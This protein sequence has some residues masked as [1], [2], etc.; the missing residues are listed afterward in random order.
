MPEGRTQCGTATLPLG[1]PV[2]LMIR[3]R[4]ETVT[5]EFSQAFFRLF[6]HLRDRFCGIRR[7]RASYERKEDGEGSNL[8][9]MSGFFAL[10]DFA[11]GLRA[12]EERDD[13]L[14]HFRDVLEAEARVEDD[15]RVALLAVFVDAADLAHRALADF[16]R[17]ALDE[18]LRALEH[19]REHV[20]DVLHRRVVE[21]DQLAQE[22]AR[23]LLL[24]RLLLLLLDR[25]EVDAVPRR[26]R[27]P[28]ARHRLPAL[29]VAVEALVAARDLAQ[30]GD[31]ERLV[32][33]RLFADRA[34]VAA[35]AD[36]P[37][38]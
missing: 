16:L 33:E 25:S 37:V 19:D 5:A 28:V 6:G 38:L 18:D 36:V 9:S 32:D 31:D 8:K 29:G 26:E 35:R 4:R 2:T 7:V 13:L 1:H 20:D 27:L 22:L 17:V 10:G 14:L 15:E 23:V 30:G 21:R 24:D 11:E 3:I 12:G 34:D